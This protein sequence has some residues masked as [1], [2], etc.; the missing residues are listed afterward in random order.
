MFNEGEREVTFLDFL[1]L[2]ESKAQPY[3]YLD[4]DLDILVV[5]ECVKP[6]MIVG[7]DFFRELEKKI[8]GS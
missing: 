6:I 4:P 5:E 2:C 7:P 1:R 8:I 3:P